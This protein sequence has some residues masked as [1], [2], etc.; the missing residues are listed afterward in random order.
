MDVA[1][2]L[3]SEKGFHATSL[4]DITSAAGVNLAAVNYHF[5]SKDAL[6]ASILDRGM[7]PVN[8]ERLRMLDQAESRAG[9]GPSALEDILSALFLPLLRKTRKSGE[10]GGSFM[11]LVGRMHSETDEHLR[12]LHSRSFAVVRSRFFAAFRLALPELSP[13]ELSWRIDFI[14]G[15]MA[16]TL[17]WHP[18]AALTGAHNTDTGAILDNLIQFCKAG[19][20]APVA[21][22][23][24]VHVE[25]AS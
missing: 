15:S 11:Q 4:R 25:V 13:R 21:E 3:F 23:A 18:E 12:Q 14:L 24:R 5:G 22:P 6:L 2:R 19:L 17:V 16:H 20:R 1:Q 9:G 7:T 8:E 10:E